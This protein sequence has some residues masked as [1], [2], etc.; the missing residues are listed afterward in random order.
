MDDSYQAYLERLSKMVQPDSYHSTLQYLCKSPKFARTTDG[1]VRAVLFPGYTLIS[2][3]NE[4]DTVNV[5]A[6]AAIQTASDALAS[7]LPEGLLIGLPPTSYHMTIADLIWDSAYRD[8]SLDP[9]YDANL[10]DR[11]AA[12]FSEVKP[13][14]VGPTCVSW[15]VLG[16]VVMPR[17]IGV[18][19]IPSDEASYRRTV[20]VRRSIYQDS[21]MMGLGIDQQY[22][23]T[24]HVTLGYFGDIPANLDRAAIAK[25]LS[26]ANQHFAQDKVV[27]SLDRAELRR[28]EDMTVY[29]R[30]PE[31]PVLNWMSS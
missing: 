26:E 7:Q 16:F 3:T 5:E 4:D 15:Q 1:V 10:R 19:L 14:V 22:H 30:E 28:F 18:C 12:L 25:T 8:L 21:A 27:L 24:A 6:Y 9:A 23:F 17:A 20:R 11:L 2:P 13:Q 31:W 29:T